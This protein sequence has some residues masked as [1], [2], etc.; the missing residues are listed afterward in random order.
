M[1]TARWQCH[2]LNGNY[3]QAR[4]IARFLTSLKIPTDTSH[5]FHSGE[6]SI[7]RFDGCS[8]CIEWT[9]RWKDAD[10]Y[11]AVSPPPTSFLLVSLVKSDEVRVDP[12][13]ER[14]IPYFFA[15]E[16]VETFPAMIVRPASTFTISHP[17]VLPFQL[18]LSPSISLFP[19]IRLD[20]S[21]MTREI[22]I[23]R[24]VEES[25]KNGIEGKLL[26]MAGVQPANSRDACGNYIRSTRHSEK[27]RSPASS[28][29]KKFA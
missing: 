4:I 11:S 23:P 29:K 1:R 5:H 6:R 13:Q 18:P 17:L 14:N 12:R 24:T 27:K 22:K 7:G 26:A 20:L 25:G 15:R 3:L 21:S 8:K 16:I 9:R 10:K 2:Y 19:R 28:P